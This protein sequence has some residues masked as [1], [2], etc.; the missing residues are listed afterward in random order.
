MPEPVPGG[1]ASWDDYWRSV[2][3]PDEDLGIGTDSIVEPG[4]HGP[5]IWFQIVPEAKTVKNRLHLDVHA[6]SGC[7]LPIE[8]PGSSGR[9]G[10]PA[11]Q[12]RGH[13]GPGAQ[14]PGLDHY[15]VAMQDP[16]GN[17]FDI[18]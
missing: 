5:R 11:G 6:S 14:A 8:T 4:G 17:E 7:P 16:E 10:G 12:P 2:G 1:F 3:V 9:R 13:A 15:G 18:N